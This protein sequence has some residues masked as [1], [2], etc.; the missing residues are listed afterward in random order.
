MMEVR[1]SKDEL[2]QIEQFVRNAIN[3]DDT[4]PHHWARAAKVLLAECDEKDG[5]RKIAE[6]TATRLRGLLRR[7]E[8]GWEEGLVKRC[9]MCGGY[10]KDYPIL[11]GRFSQFIGHADDCELAAEFAQGDEPGLEGSDALDNLL[12]NNAELQSDES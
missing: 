9:P 8:W 5:Y 3:T 7:V 4:Q 12:D 2:N 10:K 6:A 1:Y 11:G